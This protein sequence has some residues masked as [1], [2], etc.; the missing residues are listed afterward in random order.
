MRKL[1]HRKGYIL[2]YTV[3]LLSIFVLSL[4]FVINLSIYEAKQSSSMR[5]KLLVDSLSSYSLKK[6]YAEFKE[7]TIANKK[8]PNAAELDELKFFFTIQGYRCEVNYEILINDNKTEGINILSLVQSLDGKSYKFKNKQYDKN[9][10]L[11]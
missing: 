7:W 8:F 3:I 5:D 2:V 1:I 11:R 10:F 4:M 6:G 9:E